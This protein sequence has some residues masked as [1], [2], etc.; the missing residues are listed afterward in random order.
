MFGKYHSVSILFKEFMPNLLA[1]PFS[2]HSAIFCDSYA[3]KLIPKEMGDVIRGI[4]N[5]FSRN[6]VRK[7][8]C[9]KYQEFVHVAE[10]TILSL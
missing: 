9:S 5:H 1:V 2:C 4:Y 6:S 3:C 8:E 10:H 7:R